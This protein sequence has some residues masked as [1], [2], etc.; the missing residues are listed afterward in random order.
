MVLFHGGNSTGGEHIATLWAGARKATHYPFQPSWDR[1]K[2]AAPF[3]R[4]DLILGIPPVSTAF[5]RC[6]EAVR[7]SQYDYEY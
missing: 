7:A 6:V 4:N 2:K 3:K 5:R 1:F